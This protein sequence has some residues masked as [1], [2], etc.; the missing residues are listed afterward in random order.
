M[1]RL[2]KL[3]VAT[4]ALVGTA[5]FAD[6]APAQTAKELIGAWT[7][8]SDE[9]VR[10]D[11][12]RVQVMG[13]NPQGLLIFDADGRYSLQLLRPGR[14][15]SRRTTAWKVAWRRTEL[16]CRGPIPTGAHTPSMRLTR[17]STL[18]S[19]TLSSRIGRELNRSGHSRSPAINC[20]TPLRLRRAEPP[21]LSGDAL[22]SSLR[23]NA[24]LLFHS[25]FHNHVGCRL[26]TR[27]TGPAGT[28]LLLREHWWR[29]AG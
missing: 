4:I 6:T 18:R 25:P 7:L 15:S 24:L 2:N 3:K 9:N 20:G 23:K 27:S 19:S 26:T 16:R 21:S 11:G 29:R 13:A 1:N 5:L 17:L 28:G 10:A 22:S 8:V 14:P 12:S